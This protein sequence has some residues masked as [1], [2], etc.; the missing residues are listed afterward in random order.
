MAFAHRKQARADGDPLTEKRHAQDVPTVE[1]AA[2]VVLE[3]SSAQA[4]ACAARC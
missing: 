3:Q 2:A 4:G 1:E